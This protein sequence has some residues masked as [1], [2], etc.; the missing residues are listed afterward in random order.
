MLAD[1]LG[2][3]MSKTDKEKGYIDG[4]CGIE[5]RYPNNI[6]YMSGYIAGENRML[7]DLALDA[8][9]DDMKPSGTN[10]TNFDFN[11]C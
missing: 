6:N 11:H 10:D 2:T 5:S 8:P 3:M 4:F 7:A 9:L 1:Y